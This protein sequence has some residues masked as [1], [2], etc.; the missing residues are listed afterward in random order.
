MSLRTHDYDRFWARRLER[1]LVPRRRG[2][3]VRFLNDARCCGIAVLYG[4]Q[5]SLHQGRVPT[6]SPR[7]RRVDPEF[8]D[9]AK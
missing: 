4:Y 5:L 9:I 2:T 7:M 6:S 8:Y 1:A 3:Q